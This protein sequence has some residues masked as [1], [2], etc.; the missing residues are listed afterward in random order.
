MAKTG[1]Y[2]ANSLNKEP[3]YQLDCDKCCAM[4][5]QLKLIRAPM[6]I[7]NSL[8][9][10]PGGLTYLTDK[11]EIYQRTFAPFVEQMSFEADLDDLLDKMESSSNSKKGGGDY[12]QSGNFATHC[13]MKPLDTK[14]MEGDEV[15]MPQL[16]AMANEVDDAI[17]SAVIVAYKH[18]YSE[19]V[20]LW[21]RVSKIFTFCR[22]ATDAINGLSMVSSS[23]IGYFYLTLSIPRSS[24]SN[25]HSMTAMTHSTRIDP[26]N[27][28]K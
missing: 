15:T 11:D 23:G 8:Y 1:V 10:N 19:R 25:L 3:H 16:H 28:D 14:A 22:A 5:L 9:L 13:G 21:S 26:T 18:I 2:I 12:M 20:A 17:L 6:C 7:E 24:V 4:I 27:H